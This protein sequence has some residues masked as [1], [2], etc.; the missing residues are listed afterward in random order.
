M[1]VKPHSQTPPVRVLLAKIGLDG[2]DRGVRVVARALRD[3]GMEVIYLGPWAS[4]EDVAAVAL[5][6]DA[7]VVGISSLA[8]DHLLV[9]DLMAALRAEDWDGAVVVGGIVQAA[10]VPVLKSAGVVRIFHPGEP[11][12]EIVDFIRSA[13]PEKRSVAP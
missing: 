4:V 7:D 1:R 5:Q 10:D 6:E 3:A 12:D 2:H 8:Y 9:P 11:L 13:A